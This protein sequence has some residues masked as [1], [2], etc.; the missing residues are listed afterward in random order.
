MK[1]TLRLYTSKQRK[2]GQLIPNSFKLAYV[3]GRY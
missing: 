3:R 1:S 2:A